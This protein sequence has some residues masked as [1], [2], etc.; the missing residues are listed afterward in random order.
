MN[1]L[2]VS[3]LFLP[4]YSGG[5]EVLTFQVA[6]EMQ[7]R[8]HGVEVLACEDWWGDGEPVSG[9]DE[10][11]EGIPVHRLRLNT[12]ASPD[13]VRA[14]YYF[15][16]VEK[17]LLPRLRARRPDLVHVHHFGHVTTAV[18]TAAY[19]LEIPVV[20]TAT[21][22]WLICP[23]SQLFR[24]DRS[25][26]NGPTNIAKCAKCVAS[27]YRRAQPYRSLIGAIPE[28]LFNLA[29]HRVAPT[30]KGMLRAARGVASLVERAEWN[31]GVARR[32]S[33]LLV[34]SRFMRERLV[35]NGVSAERMEQVS[36]GID[37][38]WAASLVPR[39]LQSPLRIGFIGAIA[40]HKGLHVLVEAFRQLG[41][42]KHARLEVYGRLDFAPPYG[43]QVRSLAAETSEIEF[44]GTFPH[45]EIGRVLSGLDVLVIPSVWYENTPLVL[46][47]ALAARVP[48]IVSDMGGLV[49]IIRDG[50]NGLVVPCGDPEA[51]AAAL[52]HCRRDPELLPR[53]ARQIAPVKTIQTYADELL[54]R[55]EAALAPA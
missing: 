6:R 32:F 13:S 2:Y 52:D 1:I 28:P 22:F 12:A 11:Y 25:L 55:Y 53:L 4:R 44:R 26:C 40:R 17:Y 10:P 21:D 15:D 50:E 51:L 46:W 45:Q 3:H 27:T 7:R 34:T 54:A 9:H 5:T 49:E 20:F 31:R 39:R 24:Y 33:R 16:A 43:D 14:Q 35:E 23:T 41:A 30:L 42:G 48:V 37:T 19:A 29:A 18:A 47:M 38:A 36:F 8:G